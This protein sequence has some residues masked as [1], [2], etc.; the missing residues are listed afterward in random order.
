[1]SK[2]YSDLRR[3]AVPGPMPARNL[4]AA[5]GA[6]RRYIISG[7]SL[8]YICSAAAAAAA[9]ADDPRAGQPESAAI[10]GGGMP[11]LASRSRPARGGS[12]PLAF[13]EVHLIGVCVVHPYT[14]S[15]TAH[16]AGHLTALNGGFRPGQGLQYPRSRGHRERRAPR[17]AGHR[18]DARARGHRTVAL[19]H[20]ASTPH[21]THELHNSVIGGPASDA[22]TQAAGPHAGRARSLRRR[23]HG[24]G[25]GGRRLPLGEPVLV[26]PHRCGRAGAAA[27]SHFKT[28]A[29]GSCLLVI[30]H[31]RTYV[32]N[33]VP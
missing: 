9:G 24:A 32:E 13:S 28:L 14:T 21:R 31:F 1:M 3:R 33:T 15:A 12:A 17:H 2:T 6:G 16:R 22:T 18:G 7:V 29:P 27:P 11:Q 4:P 23:R 5:H 10:H 26:L 19:H 20:R 30:K 25:A 8:L